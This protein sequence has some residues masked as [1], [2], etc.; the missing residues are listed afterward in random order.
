MRQDIEVTLGALKANHFDARFAESATEART[1]MLEMIP[2]RSRVGVGDSATIRQIGVLAELA[3]RGSEVVNPFTSELTQDMVRDP[4][5]HKLFLELARKTLTTDVFLAG[6]NAVTQDG[7]IVNIDRSGNRVAGI[8]Y[9]APRVILAIGRNKI[10]K[11]VDDAIYRIKNVIAPA[12][13]QRKGRKTPCAVTGKCNECDSPDRLC[14]VTII[15]EKKPLYTDLAVILINED[16]GLGWD[17]TWDEK[18]IGKIRSSY[19]ENTWAYI[20]PNQKD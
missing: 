2:V 13:A 1:M 18:H 9:G 3:R 8:I 12:H 15:L 19:Y 11:D 20:V 6:S 10:V 4:T 16:L 5:K 17:P 7:K 14:S